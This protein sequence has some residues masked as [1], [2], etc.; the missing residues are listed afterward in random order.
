ME[1]VDGIVDYAY[2]MM[3]AQKELKNT[4]AAVLRKDFDAA[5]EHARAALA[6]ADHG[7]VLEMGEIAL[8]GPAQDLA[9]DPRVIDTYLGAAKT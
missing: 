2:P 6:V 5:L 7:Y 4:H 3:M 1:T 9:S 8:H